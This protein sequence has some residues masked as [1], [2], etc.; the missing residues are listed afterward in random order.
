MEL[1]LKNAYP[2]IVITSKFVS[3]IVITN[4]VCKLDY[5]YIN[6]TMDVLF[7]GFFKDVWEDYITY[8]YKYSQF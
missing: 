7:S 4:D 2:Q 6:I 5:K 3:V 8:M 1:V